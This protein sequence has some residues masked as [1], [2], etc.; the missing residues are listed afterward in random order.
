MKKVK[1]LLALCAAATAF[2]ALAFANNVAAIFNWWSSFL[3]VGGD[4]SAFAAKA[5]GFVPWLDWTVVDYSAVTT[6]IPALG[7]LCMTLSLAR[8]AAG[9]RCRAGDFPTLTAVVWVFLVDRPLVRPY[10][11]RL[12]E[13]T[14]LAETDDGDLAAAVDRL[15]V[16]LGAASDAFERRQREF[17]AEFRRRLDEYA[18]E[19][20][21]RAAADAEAFERRRGEYAA[22]FEKRLADYEQSFEKRQNEYVEFFK[23]EIDALERRAKAADEARVE[24]ESRLARIAAALRG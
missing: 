18:A 23:R 9:R 8:M 2:F 6:F 11:T 20:S 22:H 13:E 10:F 7:F 5:P 14:G 4:S 17:E 21:K 15:V 19:A 1:V 12:L 3:A 16:R 24:T